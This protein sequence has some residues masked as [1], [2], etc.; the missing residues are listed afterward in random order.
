M[1]AEQ[2]ETQIRE[3]TQRLNESN[4]KRDKFEVE[5][6]ASIDKIFVLREIITE[7]ETQVETKALN[8]HVLSEKNKVR[9]WVNNYRLWDHDIIMEFTYLEFYNIKG[10]FGNFFPYKFYHFCV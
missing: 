4:A 3:L 2:L 8:E 6:K 7:L 9:L 1:Q 10:L 5:L